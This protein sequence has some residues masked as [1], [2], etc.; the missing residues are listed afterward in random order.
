MADSNQLPRKHCPT[1]F[2]HDARDIRQRRRQTRDAKRKIKHPWGPDKMRGRK[3]VVGGWIAAE[4]LHVADPTTIPEHLH[5][6]DTKA[7]LARMAHD[8]PVLRRLAD[9]WWD[10]ELSERDW[11]PPDPAALDTE[12]EPRAISEPEYITFDLDAVLDEALR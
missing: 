4:H 11:T 6:E 8:A 1:A 9:N 7:T 12:E 5:T 10:R 2:E 3:T